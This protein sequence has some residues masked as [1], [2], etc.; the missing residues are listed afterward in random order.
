MILDPLLWHLPAEPSHLRLQVPVELILVAAI[1]NSRA[2][3]CTKSVEISTVSQVDIVLET[4]VT[5]TAI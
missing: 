4:F 5:R 2:K 3:C 1:L